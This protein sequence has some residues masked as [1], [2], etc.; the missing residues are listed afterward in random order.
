MVREL[1][2]VLFIFENICRCDN[3]HRVLGEVERKGGEGASS[4][5]LNQMDRT[6]Q[7]HPQRIFSLVVLINYFIMS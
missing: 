2:Q 3:H 1:E 4:L 7:V 5:A 6:Y